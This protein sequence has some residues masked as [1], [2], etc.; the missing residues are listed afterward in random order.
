MTTGTAK[1]G[2]RSTRGRL[3][4]EPLVHFVAIGA[5]L[6][7]LYA[8]VGEGGIGDLDPTIRLTQSDVNGIRTA[9]SRRWGR[10]PDPIELRSLIE[11]R[12]REEV[13]YREAVAMGLDQDDAIV[14]RR[15]VQKI[16][17]L[18]EDLTPQVEP[19]PDESET[20]FVEH[21]EDYRLP[22]RLTFTHVYLS[23]DQRGPAVASDAEALLVRLRD[24]ETV[25]RPSG[26]GDRFMLQHD[27]ALQSAREIAR[28]F[29]GPFANRLM[30]LEPGVWQ[31]PVESGFGLHL[32]LIR[33]RRE[34]LLPALE[35][36]LDQVRLD[37]Q[38]QRRRQANEAFYR[39][40][41][42][43]YRVEIEGFEI[44]WAKEGESSAGDGS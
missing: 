26:L 8:L 33:E 6:F 39:D 2:S 15:M 40:L 22:L 37:F 13:L 43:R 41:R 19:S 11:E 27:Y 29:G 36:V 32:V 23:R 5:F 34:S 18:S 31:G 12:I 30:E 38:S 20:F 35:E 9:W 16:E 17:F 1:A 14:R 10:A 21:L 24:L 25:E 4:H 44:D 3:L 28:L 7:G 42:Q